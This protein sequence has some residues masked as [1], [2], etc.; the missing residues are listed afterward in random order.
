MQK[1]QTHILQ[2]PF[3]LR[4][5]KCVPAFILAVLQLHSTVCPVQTQL[6]LNVVSNLVMCGVL[7]ILPQRKRGKKMPSTTV[8]KA[9]HIFVNQR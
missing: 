4:S 2:F 5:Y 3:L 6:L 1:D 8:I 7:E 9:N